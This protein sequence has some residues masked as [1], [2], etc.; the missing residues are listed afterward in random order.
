MKTLTKM[1][2][3]L[4]IHF[5]L[6]LGSA[7]A[8]TVAVTVGNGS[9]QAG[10][11]TGFHVSSG[12]VRNFYASTATM[13]NALMTSA[14]AYALRV[15]TLTAENL[16]MNVKSY[17]AKG[18]GT[19]D[20]TTA[21][22]NAITA[23]PLGATLFIPRGTYKITGQ[24]T[25]AQNRIIIL[26]EGPESYIA[27]APAGNNQTLFTSDGTRDNIVYRNFAIEQ[28]NYASKTNA[29]AFYHPTGDTA[30]EWDHVFV[31]NFNG[32]GIQLGVSVIYIKIID[33]RFIRIRDTT[34]GRVP[35]AIYGEG[36]NVMRI[37]KCLFSENDRSITI[38]GGAPIQI[39]RNSFELD[40]DSGN[41]LTDY[42]VS[43]QN[44]Q[45]FAFTDNYVEG[46][47]YTT[48]GGALRMANIKNAHIADNY[49][50]GE[51][52]PTT[53]TPNFIIVTGTN[54]RN[55][56]IERN[57]FNEILTNFILNQ[58][59]VTIRNNY[60]SD[61]HAELSTQA[62]VMALMND[63]TLIDS[64]LFA[65]T[66]WDPASVS[67]SSSTTTT[68]TY[69]GAV[70]GNRVDVYPPYTLSG[71]I[72]TG[73]VSATNTVTIVLS[74]PTGGS[75]DLGSGSWQVNVKKFR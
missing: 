70:V 14:T 63:P 50:S 55:C 31:S 61:G 56:I 48:G 23:M 42:S 68:V 10:T 54:T 49:F 66:T 74:N 45:S 3:L 16:W 53:Y 11:T 64:D 21:F 37:E 28:T 27:Y 26:G 39:A 36:N 52:G 17:G 6:R 32:Y 15:S 58:T 40:G 69:A 43:V 73:Y 9:L 67:A 34:S 71:L 24:L 57:S 65:S 35:I 47:S 5:L 1:L 18:N 20:D 38:A 51:D 62:Q 4:L 2:F 19:T 12:T 75:V 25:I 46:S 44:S 41:T 59:T 29:R 22:Q 8:A 33:C 30:L 60:F 13:T 7:Q 72:A